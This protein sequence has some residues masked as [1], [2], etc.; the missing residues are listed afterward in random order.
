VTI[1]NSGSTGQV[2]TPGSGAGSGTS[3]TADATPVFNFAGT[4]NGS[5]TAG[6]VAG[7]LAASMPVVIPV[8]TLG[9]WALLLFAVGLALTGCFR[10]RLR[11]T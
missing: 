4:V 7:A 5:G 10:G 1:T 8:P 9:T 3:G 2:A 6:P 11:A